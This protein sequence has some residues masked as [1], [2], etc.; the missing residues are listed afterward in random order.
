MSASLRAGVWDLTPAD[1][2]LVEARRWGN[3]L[4]FAVMLLFFRARGRFP[5]AAAEVDKD[6]VAELARTLGVPEPGHEAP[7]L[8]D[9]AGRTLERQRA[10]I[11]ALLGYREAGVADAE[12]L[13]AWLRDNAV[14]RTRDPGELAAEAEA[15]CRALRIEPPTPDRVARIVRAAV[16][17][18]EDRRYAAVHTRLMLDMRA[19][20]DALLEPVG[21]KGAENTED[22]TV[23]EGRTDAPLIHLRAGPGRASVASLRDEL[24]RLGTIRQLGLP[25]NLFTDWSQQELEAGR[26]RV[27]VEA[28]H[29]LR[30]HPEATRHV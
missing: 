18:Y 29:E 4:R 6:A 8:P 14:A 11:R 24:A 19:R 2:L 20:L 30:R 3:R 26:Q 21:P 23:P 5:H 25:A 10:E 1:R 27:A 28:P 22:E 15:R 12:A 13:G 9:A 16:R 7:L 17:A